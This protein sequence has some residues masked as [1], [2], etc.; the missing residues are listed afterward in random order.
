MFDYFDNQSSLGACGWNGMFTQ[1]GYKA[2]DNTVLQ[3]LAID[4]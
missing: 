2:N 4:M 3:L 1:L